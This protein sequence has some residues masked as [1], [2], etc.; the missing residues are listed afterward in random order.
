MSADLEERKEM[1]NDFVTE[2]KEM[3]DEIEPLIIEL[4]KNSLEQ[5]LINEEV[6]NRVFR[7]FHSIKGMSSFLDLQTVMK[8]THEVETLLDIF[9]KGQGVLESSY[10]DLLYR[11]SDFIRGLLEVITE[12]LYDDGFEKEAENIIEEIQ[13]KIVALKEGGKSRQADPPGFQFEIS[14]DLLKQFADESMDAFDEA[15]SA[16][17]AMETSENKREEI[18]RIFRAFHSFKGNAGFFGYAG[19]EEVSHKAESILD[20]VRDARTPIHEKLISTLLIVIDFLR[21]GVKKMGIGQRD[22]LPNKEGMLKLLDTL[23]PIKTLGGESAAAEQFDMKTETAPGIKEKVLQQ[24]SAKTGTNGNEGVKQAI[25]VDLEKLDSMMDLVGELVIAEAM[26]S[27]SPDLKGLELPRFEKSIIQ[28]GKIVRD[29]QDL[30]MSMRMIPLA[31]TFKKMVRLVR[32]LAYKEGKKVELEILGEETEVDK[33]I[34]EQI[35]DPLIHLIRNAV[36][37]GIEMPEQRIAVGKREIGQITIEA[38]HSAGEVWIIVKDDGK[39][40]N[41]EK[42]LA[43]AFENGLVPENKELKDEDVWKFVFEPGLSTAEKVSSVSGR[44]VGMDV[45]KQN[46]EKIH[47]KIEIRTTPGEGSV[48][49]VRIPLTLA[50]IE[51]MVAQVGNA[52]YTI[53]INTVNESIRPQDSQIT[54]TP[55]GLEVIKIRNELIPVIRL[56]EVFRIRPLHAVLTE[57]IL[58]VVETDGHKTCIFVDEILGQQQ[59]VIKGLPE[60][61]RHIRGVLGMAI[62]GDGEVSMILDI[63]NLINTAEALMLSEEKSVSA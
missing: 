7:I 9:R 59:I 24:S 53:P 18:E 33:T 26:V 10:T 20:D 19:F 27:H 1:V 47:G 40:L 29:I 34:I 30:S 63:S 58:I 61:L 4:E 46:I 25:R 3:L 11:S 56:H 43:K 42:I 48:F 6:I 23:S 52:C 51:G 2:S 39:G 44:G 35:S 60:Y 15:E 54:Y 14:A 50:I 22:E 5:G 45:V 21:E 55:D 12:R 38:K 13:Q 28:L 57:G 49:I 8:V 31:G 17:L 36:D 32:D 37:H 16:L 41:R 62:L